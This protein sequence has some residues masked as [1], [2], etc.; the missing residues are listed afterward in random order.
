MFRTNFLRILFVFLGLLI[1]Q[2]IASQI[3]YR[4]DLTVDKRYS[5]SD[6]SIA[7]I[8][9]IK[10]SIRVDVFLNGKLPQEY[11]RL[12]SETEILL[13]SVIA[14]NDHFYYE[15][16]DP[17]KGSIN[18]EQLINEMSQ[19]GLYPELVVEN[20]NQ[21]TEQS[22]VFPWMLL[23]YEDRTIRVSLLQ[24]NLGDQ[25]EK[26]IL[27]SIQQLEFALMD[28][29]HQILLD[30][31]KKIAVLKSHNTSQDILITSFLQDLLLSL[32]HI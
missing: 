16:I 21:V 14:Q 15:F 24:K 5:L 25:P 20:T 1:I 23:N 32:I 17:Y 9:P 13:Q 26:R 30:E 10:K 8:K 22:Y 11:Q 31:K 27:Q 6:E 2:I 12:R 7:F 3:N 18:T 19:Y 4:W 29:I 28:G